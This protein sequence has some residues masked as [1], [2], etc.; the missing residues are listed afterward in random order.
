MN[1]FPLTWRYKKKAIYMI[2]FSVLLYCFAP[3]NANGQKI[4][5][6]VIVGDDVACPGLT[7]EYHIGL[8]LYFPMNIQWRIIDGPGEFVGSDRGERVEIQWEASD[9]GYT[10]LVMFAVSYY[11]PL[12]LIDTINIHVDKDLNR[13]NLNCFGEVVLDFGMECERYIDVNELITNGK[14]K[15]LDDFEFTLEMENFIVPN[16]VPKTFNGREMTA[17]ITHK[18]TGQFCRTKITLG[19]FSGPRLIA[20]NDTVLCSDPRAYDPKNNLFGQP[21]VIAD[22]N[23][24][25]TLK[26]NEYKWVNVDADPYIEGF[27]ERVW[28][29][30]DQN[31]NSTDV[32]DTVFL[33]KIIF[34]EIVCPA[35]TEITCDSLELLDQPLLTG[36]PMFDG[37]AIYSEDPYC[38]IYVTYEDEEIPGCGGS[39]TIFRTWL[40]SSYEGEDVREK[41]CV[42]TIEVI[43]TTGPKILFNEEEYTLES[44]S[45][46]EGAISGSSYPTFYRNAI[47][48]GCRAEGDF[49]LPEFIQECSTPDELLITI[50]WNDNKIVFDI[51]NPTADI[52]FRNM[53]IGK[54][55]VEYSAYD[56]CM[57]VGRDTIVLV[58]SDKK[59]PTLV[60]DDD[61]SV[62][63]SNQ[64][65]LAWVDVASFDEGSFDNCELEILLARRVD[66]KTACGY[67]EDVSVESTV[68]DYYDKHAAWV[69]F[70]ADSCLTSIVGY[71]WTDKIPFCCEDACTD[72]VLVE[73]LAIDAFCNYSKLVTRVKV[74][75][76][77]KAEVK[78]RLPN[79]SMNCYTYQTLYQPEVAKGNTSMFGSY[80]TDP[81]NQ[82]SRTL[83]IYACSENRISPYVPSTVEVTDGLIVDN[84]NVKIEETFKENI[85]VCG[86]GYLERIFTIS[87]A[88]SDGA[89][90]ES[91]QVIQKIFITKD[92]RLRAE[93]FTLPYADTTVFNCSLVDVPPRGPEL[94]RAEHCKD[95]G[96]AYTDAVLKAVENNGGVCYTIKRTWE[97][98][99]WCESDPYYLPEF[100]Q[101]IYINNT[102]GPVVS[103][104]KI[105]DI[106]IDTGCDY[107]MNK[108]LEVTDDCSAAEELTVIW[109]IEKNTLEGWKSVKSGTGLKIQ[110]LRINT[111]QYRLV[112]EAEDLCHNQTQTT[113]E[114][115]VGYCDAL[116]IDGPESIT[117]NLNSV[118]DQLRLI[119]IPYEVVHP[120]P[121]AKYDV[122]LRYKGMGLVDHDGNVLPPLPGSTTL[123]VTCDKLGSNLL[124]L[125]VIDDSG[126]SSFYVLTMEVKDPKGLCPNSS[127]LLV[128]NVTMPDQQPVANVSVR[129][130]G[131][132]AEIRRNV[133]NDEGSF[134]LG[135]FPSTSSNLMIQPVKDDSP[136]NGITAFDALS[137][138]RMATD[139]STP[140]TPYEK[141]AADINEDGIISVLDVLMIQSLLLNKIDQLP[142]RQWLFINSDMQPVSKIRADQ[143][144]RSK[145]HFV[146]VKKG[147]VNYSASVRSSGRHSGPRQPMTL[148]TPE[149]HQGFVRVP[150]NLAGNSPV[151]SMQ[152]SLRNSNASPWL[153]IESGRL[154][155]G[156]QDYR[157]T[158][159]EL[160]VV[161]IDTDDYLVN[162]EEKADFYLIFDQIS[163]QDIAREKIQLTMNLTPEI[164][165]NRVLK[166]HIWLELE[167]RSAEFKVSNPYPNPFS[168]QVRMDLTGETGQLRR[169][170][171][172]NVSGKMVYQEKVEQKVSQYVLD[173]TVF[174]AA[175]FY[176]VRLIFESGM[177]NKK[178]YY[179][180]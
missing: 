170:E 153:A 151:E 90:D 43:D 51:D 54:Y 108:T 122:F 159:Q 94:I 176:T 12:G 97:I 81:E 10:Q 21:E 91:I 56:D 41:T 6:N 17:T 70:Q 143:E 127:N 155:I 149:M 148:G 57:N 102:E 103:N 167:N 120:C 75:D 16:P 23:E 85:G 73:F 39:K 86:E 52:R 110:N 45:D 175:G 177:V 58:L 134:N 44:H 72:G 4:L 88:C 140:T 132:V 46:L 24:R 68:R 164:Y 126:N 128:G 40:I 111:G 137:I 133:T 60:L 71:G 109:R 100:V 48:D 8:D 121:D 7:N 26:V 9:R 165:S 119:D 96:I 78:Y 34:E 145:L 116:K 158:E 32:T 150:V 14:I 20:K 172:Y 114:F 18:E 106:C 80:V 141:L 50:K 154:Q 65:S 53:T 67:S 123:N 66:W 174:P 104:A 27:I 115:E 22:C 64:Q 2:L 173:G 180:P 13:M 162:A 33:R 83:D 129:L 87:N 138:F 178:L 89:G 49:P 105:A 168:H 160:D 29:A 139:K 3:H 161:W 63:L 47:T 59:P 142:G 107:V 28:R 125:W 179:L 157:M 30:T 95:L 36:S 11:P 130:N 171:I 112:V 25:Y 35:D 79:V 99:D 5:N 19:D 61:P 146:G 98:S 152:F 55:L 15:C 117:F 124:E 135:Q 136:H 1:I 77:S 163:G 101:Y 62:S 144:Y 113:S 38:K 93:D 69:D 169:S 42:Q 92:C 147:D 31:G 131:P 166:E 76:R 156:S 84:C 82:A 74:S 118:N 37:Q